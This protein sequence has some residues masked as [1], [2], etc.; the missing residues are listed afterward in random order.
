MQETRRTEDLERHLV[1][2]EHV[3]GWAVG[4]G[5]SLVLVCTPVKPA[6]AQLSAG[7]DVSYNSNVVGGSW[8][9]GGRAGVQLPDVGFARWKLV[10]AGMWYTPNCSG[11]TCDWWELQGTLMFSQSGSNPVSPYLGVGGIYQS[12]NLAR[13][14]VDDTDWGV[15]LLIGT[16][17]GQWGPVLPY[18]EVRYKVM[19]TISN[20][21]VFQLGF[22]VGG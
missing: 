17:I 8:G 6:A 7:A 19:H 21:F 10:G 1:N 13:A 14:T 3:R 20:Q 4:L 12:F 15:D 2:L 22:G 18:V 9:F 5:L 16:F 11:G